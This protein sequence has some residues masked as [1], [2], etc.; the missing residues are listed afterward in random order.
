MNDETEIS[1]KIARYLDSGTAELKAGTAYRLQLA[2]E[3]ALSR[4]GRR[5]ASG[6]AVQQPHP[7]PFLETADGLAEG[8]LR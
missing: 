6:R 8:R 4:L 7:E 1:T 2:R 3:Q 5:H